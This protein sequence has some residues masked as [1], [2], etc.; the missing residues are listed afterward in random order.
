SPQTSADPASAKPPRPPLTWPGD[1]HW[2]TCSPTTAAGGPASSASGRPCWN[3][4]SGES[5]VTDTAGLL[6][7]LTA[8]GADLDAIV[9]TM[10]K[11]A[12]RTMTPADGWT[13]AHQNAHLTLTH[14][15]A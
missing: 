10:D 13:V 14:A 6:A 9:S 1:S 3:A 15:G 7:D 11:R 8:E 5:D 12:W 2:P 4:Y